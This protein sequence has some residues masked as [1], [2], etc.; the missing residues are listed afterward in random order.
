MAGWLVVALAVSRAIDIAIR[1]SE[2]GALAGRVGRYLFSGVATRF[3]LITCAVTLIVTVSEG[4]TDAQDLLYL[5]IFSMIF[6][7]FIGAFCG[8][9][10][11]AVGAFAAWG[12]PQNSVKPV[13]LSCVLLAGAVLAAPVVRETNDILVNGW[14]P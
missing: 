13:C 12:F 14:S 1:H 5:G 4:A 3:A 6:G 7:A 11:G 9:T 8:V 10:L 2:P